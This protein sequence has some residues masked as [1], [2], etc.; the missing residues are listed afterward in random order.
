MLAVTCILLILCMTSGSTKVIFGLFLRSFSWY[1]QYFLGSVLTQEEECNFTDGNWCNF[2]STGN[3]HWFLTTGSKLD[4]KY[5]KNVPK[6]GFDGDPESNIKLFLG[7]KWFFNNFFAD[8]F[9][10]SIAEPDKFTPSSS[11]RWVNKKFQVPERCFSF[12][13]Y[14]S[15]SFER[16]RVLVEKSNSSF[17]VQEIKGGINEWRRVHFHLTLEHNGTI[18]FEVNNTFF[19]SNVFERL[20]SQLFWL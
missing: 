6:S 15:G 7:K 4:L 1:L 19:Y 11:I 3:S 9:L 8:Q 13:V 18:L 2:H 10:A 14:L 17:D 12:D 5:S 20:T 16:L